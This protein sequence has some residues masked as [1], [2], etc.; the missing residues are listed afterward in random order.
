MKERRESLERDF[1]IS[2]AKRERE[3]EESSSLKTLF[4]AGERRKFNIDFIADKST[5]IRS[6]IKNGKVKKLC[7]K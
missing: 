4:P 2:V 6:S 7:M 1:A 3:R 5:L